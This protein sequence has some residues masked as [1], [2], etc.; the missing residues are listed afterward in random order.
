MGFRYYII[1]N[2]SNSVYSDNIIRVFV[3]PL[4]GIS[5]SSEAARRARGNKGARKTWAVA[6]RTDMSSFSPQFRTCKFIKIQNEDVS[7]GNDVCP[8]SL[9]SFVPHFVATIFLKRLLHQH[10]LPIVDYV[11][12][13]STASTAVYKCT[14]P[15]WS[16]CS[17]PHFQHDTPEI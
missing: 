14:F 16:G 7:C 3:D 4:L 9:R 8:A 6:M 10:S 17:M 12:R 1:S 15:S 11:N 5:A 13:G 2:S